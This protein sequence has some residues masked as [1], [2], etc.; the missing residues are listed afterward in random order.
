LKYNA[1]SVI[2]AHNHPSGEM[3]PS[4]AD[5]KLTQKL[6][7]VLAMIDVRILDHL[8]IGSSVLSMAE[9]GLL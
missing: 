1:A 3:T 6:R 8:I 2:L 5:R 4:M 9:R 7:D